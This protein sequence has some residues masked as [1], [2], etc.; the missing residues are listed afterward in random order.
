MNRKRDEM[1]AFLGYELL[2]RELEAKVVVGPQSWTDFCTVCRRVGLS[3][4]IECVESCMRDHGLKHIPVRIIA[5]RENLVRRPEL[6]C[7]A[8]NTHFFKQQFYQI[9]LPGGKCCCIGAGFFMNKKKVPAG[10]ELYIR[11]KITPML[12]VGRDNKAGTDFVSA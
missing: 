9:V 11:P 8:W 7:S 12:T 4:T 1:R 3:E 10:Q 5:K 6:Q 2:P